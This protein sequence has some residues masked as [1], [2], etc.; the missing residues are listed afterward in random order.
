[1]RYFLDTEHTDDGERFE[2]ISIA[3]VSEDGREYY[4][5]VKGYESGAVTA[6]IAEDVLPKLPPAGDPLWKAREQIRDDVA[7]FVP[8]TTS[9]SGRCVRGRTGRSSCGSSDGSRKSRS[10]GRWR[11][12][13]CG[14]SRP[15]SESQGPSAHRSQR[16]FTMRWLMPAITSESTTGFGA[17]S[18]QQRPTDGGPRTR[19]PPLPGIPP[20]R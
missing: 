6:W 4:A 18:P 15:S 13:I 10:R 17:C 2:L 20:I 5:A 16:A 12:W 11:A 3:V 9:S 19:S 8:E 14:S 1:M 7:A